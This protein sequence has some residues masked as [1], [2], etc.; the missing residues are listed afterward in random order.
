MYIEVA[1]DVTY[2]FCG[3]QGASVVFGPQKG[4]TPE[5]VYELDQALDIMHVVFNEIS[6][7][8]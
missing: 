4:A 5:M 6:A 1:C 8:Q 2:P 7:S 3:P